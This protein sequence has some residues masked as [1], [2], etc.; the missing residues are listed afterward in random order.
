MAECDLTKI[1]CDLPE[2]KDD[3][4]IN[5]GIYEDCPSLNRLTIVLAHF[6][7]VSYSHRIT[8]KLFSMCS[9]IKL[10][11]SY[12]PVELLN[13][14]DHIVG[15]ELNHGI[16]GY[17]CDAGLECIH[18]QRATRDRNAE[19][20]KT[21]DFKKQFFNTNNQSDFVYISMLDRAHCL[22]YHSEE[23]KKAG[24][25]NKNTELMQQDTFKIQDQHMSSVAMT[26]A[27]C[28]YMEYYTLKPLYR[29]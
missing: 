19:K 17:T 4:D 11:P 20:C 28:V 1:N 18:F 5:I 2:R 10:F 26:Y 21:L 6:E 15:H 14:I 16:I 13:D 12:S 3:Y 8:I 22:L 27:T 29:N 23:M 9:F 7:R 24:T 25:M